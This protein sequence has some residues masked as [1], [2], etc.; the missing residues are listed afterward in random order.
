MSAVK[1]LPVMQEMRVRSLSGEDP[2]EEEMASAP[3]FLFG[4]SAD[5]GASGLQSMGS[6]YRAEPD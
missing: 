2:L 1:N 5:R 4:K 6:S 3:V